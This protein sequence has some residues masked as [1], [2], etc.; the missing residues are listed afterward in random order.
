MPQGRSGI[1]SS[2]AP[3]MFLDAGEVW[4]NIDIAA[5]ED[6][7]AS[8]P[9]G[10]ATSASGA[11]KLG[12]T[13]GG[14]EFNP[15]RVIRQMP[16]DG[17]V[18]PVKGFNRRQSSAPVLTCNILEL[19]PENLTAAIAGGNT[20]T[21][22]LFERISGGEIEDS[23][24]IGNVALAT[25]LKGNPDHPVV[26]V[27]LNALVLEAPTFSMV[28]EDETVLAVAFTGHVDVATPNTE[29]FFIYHPGLPTPP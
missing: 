21:R 1:S 13:R 25:T 14:N 10:A 3:N 20:D 5:L 28:D 12:G 11:L 15:N 18:G 22:G 29:A 2:T 24:Y 27:V 16:V 4:L 9:W 6:G 23:D 26:I 7:S 19:T 8:D 17:A